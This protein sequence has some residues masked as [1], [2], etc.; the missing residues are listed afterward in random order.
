LDFNSYPEFEDY[1]YLKV[2]KSLDVSDG[3][4]PSS[5]IGK[6][7]YYLG[8][9]LRILKDKIVD[10]RIPDNIYTGSKNAYTILKAAG[11]YFVVKGTP[12][13]MTLGAKSM[14]GLSSIKSKVSN[15]VVKVIFKF[16]NI[17][18]QVIGVML[19]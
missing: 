12:V 19:I 13:V 6:V 7:K 18:T 1:Q 11:K 3:D 17:I 2:S 5:L 9:S 8:K 14:E 16:S 4:Y 10:F 15:N